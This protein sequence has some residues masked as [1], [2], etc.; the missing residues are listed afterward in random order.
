MTWQSKTLKRIKMASN[1]KLPSS[2][3][4]FEEWASIDDKNGSDKS[5]NSGSQN[6]SSWFLVQVRFDSI[7]VVFLFVLIQVFNSFVA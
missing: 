1:E 2:P 7:I 4:G 3:N 6:S 5:S